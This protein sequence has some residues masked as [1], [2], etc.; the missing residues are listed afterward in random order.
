MQLIVALCGS[1]VSKGKSSVSTIHH[2]ESFV[3]PVL[4]SFGEN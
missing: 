3:I 2:K 4:T 1:H